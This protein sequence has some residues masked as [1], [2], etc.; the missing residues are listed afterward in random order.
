MCSNMWSPA[1]GTILDCGAFKRQGL[2]GSTGGCL[3]FLSRCCDRRS[4]GGRAASGCEDPD[5]Q[6]ERHDAGSGLLLWQLEHKGLLRVREPRAQARPGLGPPTVTHILQG[7]P[8]LLEVPHFPQTVPPEIKVS[9]LGAYGRYFLTKL[10]QKFHLPLVQA[11]ALLVHAASCSAAVE[12]VFSLC[13]HFCDILK[14]LRSRELKQHFSH[15]G[16]KR[17]QFNHLHYHTPSWLSVHLRYSLQ[18]VQRCLL[19]EQGEL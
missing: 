5:H 9:N 19:L 15:S 7:A 1:G 10:P 11:A 17:N 6:W 12:H 3:S 16:E 13:F 2:V 8:H 18:P 4:Q 14:S